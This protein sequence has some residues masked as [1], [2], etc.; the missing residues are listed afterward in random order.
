MHNKVKHNKDRR[1]AFLVD[2]DF[3]MQN[4]Q[5][6]NDYLVIGIDANKE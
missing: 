4:F 1:Q 5:T 6:E 2:E 3:I